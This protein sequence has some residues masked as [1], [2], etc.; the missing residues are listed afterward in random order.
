MARGRDR[1]R[2]EED[3]G[4]DTARALSAAY[5]RPLFHFAL[6]LSGDRARAEEVVQDA[7]LRA[8]QH[9][10]AVDG[11]RGEAGAFLFTVVRNAVIDGWR[12]DGARP[13]SAGPGGL[14]AGTATASDEV[15]RAVESWGVAE[16]MRRLTPEHRQVLLHTFFLDH[17]VEQT[18]EA[19]GIPAGTV[20]SRTYYGLRS[21]RVVLQ[22]MGYVR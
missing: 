20:K 12:R 13:R 19:L 18:A 2:P 1:T 7:L 5:A 6:R 14:E 22:E 8:W 17:S 3:Q 10:E 4:E 16:A 11:S 9:P 15:D 21:L